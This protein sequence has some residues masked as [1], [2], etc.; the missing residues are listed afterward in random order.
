MNKEVSKP[1]VWLLTCGNRAGTT[2]VDA[3]S[4]GILDAE[5]DGG[6]PIGEETDQAKTECS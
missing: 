1:R 5:L 4:A 6:D 3:A 2:A